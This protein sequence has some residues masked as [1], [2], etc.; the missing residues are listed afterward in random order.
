MMLSIFSC[1]CWPSRYLLWRNIYQ[2]NFYWQHWPRWS[3]EKVLSW[4]K[5]FIIERRMFGEMFVLCLYYFIYSS[6]ISFPFQ[7]GGNWGSRKLSN[8]AKVVKLS[9]WWS[10]DSP[11]HRSLCLCQS[12]QVASVVSKGSQGV[13]GFF[14]RFLQRSRGTVHRA[15]NAPQGQAWSLMATWL[16]WA[17]KCIL[18]C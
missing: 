10:R 18:T 13:T 11:G 8:L 4:R 2:G 12:S 16:M 3:R 6:Q 17:A 5:G 9:K 7:R 15:V 1:V 14:T